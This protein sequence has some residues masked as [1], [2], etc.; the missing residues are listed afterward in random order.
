MVRA[1]H[2][3]NWHKKCLKYMF[4]NRTRSIWQIYFCRYKLSCKVP[5]Q[6]SPCYKYFLYVIW[7]LT[8]KNIQSIVS[9][10]RLAPI[11]LALQFFC[12]MYISSPIYIEILK[13]RKKYTSLM[14]F[15]YTLYMKYGMTGHATNFSLARRTF[16]SRSR[17]RDWNI[18]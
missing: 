9:F 7:N 10:F 5:V 12:Y 11:A 4:L 8:G 6:K 14:F 13:E 1:L 3:M 16:W 15:A 17:P 2:W 18:Y